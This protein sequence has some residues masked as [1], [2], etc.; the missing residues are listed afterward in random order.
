MTSARLARPIARVLVAL[1]VVQ[2]T[3][4]LASLAAAGTELI[5][6]RPSIVDFLAVSAIIGVFS[7]VGYA[8]AARRPGNPV[9]WLFLVMGLSMATATFTTEYVDRV[10]FADANLPAPVIAAWFS[11]WAWTVGP[12]VALPLAIILFPEGRLPSSRWRALLVLTLALPVGS[13]VATAVAPG[14]LVGNEDRYLNPLGVG[15]P[16]GELALEVVGSMVVGVASF[17]L[18]GVLAIAATVVRI[19]RSRGA[20]RQQLK[21]LLYPVAVFVVAI[22]T[23]S[24]TQQAWSWTLA[25]I[26]FAGIPIAAGI[27]ILRYRLY[28]IDVVIRRTLVYGVL[29]GVLGLVYVSMVLVLQAALSQITGGETLPVA[30]STL[31]IAALFGPVRSRVRALVDR[32]FYRARYDAQRTLEAFAGRLRDEVELDAVGGT[33]VMVAGR[34]VQPVSM[35]LWVRRRP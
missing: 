21:W 16:L 22:A 15:G 6:A 7:A 2:M 34:A 24:V 26:S 10:T 4:S 28:D 19:R 20:E 25:L 8:V 29:V 18:P 1:V 31:A 11:A 12:V 35:N 33:L 32:R 3:A 23:A 30:L 27:A 17:V 13:I 14:P 5:P 9:G